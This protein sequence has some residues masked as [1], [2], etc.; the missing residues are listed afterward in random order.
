MIGL[1][2]WIEKRNFQEFSLLLY[3]D[4]VIGSWLKSCIG[5]GLFIV[6]SFTLFFFFKFVFIILFFFYHLDFYSLCMEVPGDP[7]SADAASI[8]VVKTKAGTSFQDLEVEEK[9]IK[10]RKKS[11]DLA[12]EALQNNL[13]NDNVIE[14]KML[15]YNTP[16]V[17]DAILDSDTNLDVEGKSA[18]DTTV[19]EKAGSTGTETGLA[20]VP[21]VADLD[22]DQLREQLDRANNRQIN[23][24]D[25][26][27]KNERDL[28]YISNDRDILYNLYCNGFTSL[29]F[30]EEE[31]EETRRILYETE[32]KLVKSEED[33]REIRLYNA[34]NIN[35]N[36]VIVSSD[37]LS[38]PK[39]EERSS[40]ETS[41][42][43]YDDERPLNSKVMEIITRG[44]SNISSHSDER[45][46]SPSNLTF[47]GVALFVSISS[48]KYLISF[49]S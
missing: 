23:L 31:L 15:T 29:R 41:D 25:K 35:I 46:E 38:D 22:I 11:F 44:P 32:N 19:E 34:F 33:L 20:L 2:F 10:D 5:L 18:P 7:E 9:L 12:K 40:S 4:P 42:D 28:N 37:D 45:K 6:S 39:E 48:L 26:L 16:K 27:N 43:S 14:K 21:V 24:E 49:F 1:T 17:I 8:V 13:A 30:R 3:T 36:N 47:L